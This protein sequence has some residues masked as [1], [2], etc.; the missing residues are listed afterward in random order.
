MKLSIATLAFLLGISA[1]ALAGQCST[2]NSIISASNSRVGLRE[3]VR[4]KIKAPLTGTVSVTAGNGP[5]FIEDGSGNPVTVH[6]NRWTD[7]VFSGMDWMCSARTHFRLP[8]PVIKDIKLI[9]Q[10]EGRIEYVVGRRNGHY[11][12]KTQTT[13]NG[14][15][16]ITLKYG[17]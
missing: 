2:Q 14:V 6:G 4:F 10:F 5:T 11:L 3:L 9:G 17:P 8:K 7:V 16:T 12:G 15:T 13:A 1:P